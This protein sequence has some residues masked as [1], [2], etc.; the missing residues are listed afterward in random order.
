MRGL[1]G[2]I[3][4]PIAVRAMLAHTLFAVIEVGRTTKFIM[5]HLCGLFVVA[6][7]F[8]RE[9]MSLLHAI[10]LW[11]QRLTPSVWEFRPTS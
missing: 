4:C 1:V 6:A 11:I 9:V 2:T 8:R 3:A 5:Q 10:Y 7:L